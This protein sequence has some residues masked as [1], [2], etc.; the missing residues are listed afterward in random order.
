MND[1]KQVANT[2]RQILLIL[3]SSSKVCFMASA[4]ELLGGV[5]LCGELRPLVVIRTAGVSEL[6]RAGY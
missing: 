5:G 4:E 3:M 6:S 1:P 2:I